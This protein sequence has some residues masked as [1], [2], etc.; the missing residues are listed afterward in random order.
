MMAMLCVPIHLGPSLVPAM[1]DSV[2]MEWLAQVRT[3]LLKMLT[4]VLYVKV[5]LTSTPVIGALL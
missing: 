4:S 2:E 5:M 3:S 1:G